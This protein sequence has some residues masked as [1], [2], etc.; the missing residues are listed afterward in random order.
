MMIHDD[1]CISC[2][3]EWISDS[4]LQEIAFR[5]LDCVTWTGSCFEFMF[6]SSPF[7]SRLEVFKESSSQCSS[8]VG[9]LQTRGVG[10]AGCRLQTA[11]FFNLGACKFQQN[12]YSFGYCSSKL[13]K[14]HLWRLNLVP[15][16]ISLAFVG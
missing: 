13:G 9:N 3:C 4:A 12:G 7:S 10:Q 5:C 8:V 15:S 6:V 11:L 14:T 2:V 1:M 16:I